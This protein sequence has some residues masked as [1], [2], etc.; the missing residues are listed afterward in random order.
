MAIGTIRRVPLPAGVLDAGRNVFR[1]YGAATSRLRPPPDFLIFGTKRGGTT[2]AYFHLLEHPQVLPLFPTA[3]FLPKRRDGK[4]PHYFDTNY[5][6]GDRWY[7]GHFPSRLTR[8]RAERRLAGPVAVGEASPYYLYHPLAA[9]RAARLVPEAKLLLFLRDPVERTHS[10]WKEQVRNRVERLDFPDALAA[11]AERTAGEEARILADPT[12]YS[13]PHEFQSYR[14]QSEYP[15]ALARWFEHFPAE[16]FKIFA[17][18]EYTADAGNVCN[19]V[20]RFLGLPERPQEK[21]PQLNAA[22][23]APMPAAVRAELDE[24]FAPLNVE[25]EKMIGRRLPWMKH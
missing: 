4:G 9:E 24:H 22:T 6:L 17:T 23:A 20:F 19:D 13:F 5:H 11:E 18:E 12:Y 10:M 25:L 16:Q 7:L 21:A 14:G 2:S 3:R 15:R 1:T 8:T